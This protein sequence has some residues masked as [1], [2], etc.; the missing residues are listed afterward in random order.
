MKEMLESYLASPDFEAGVVASTKAS[1]GGS[2]YSVELHP[3]GSWSNLWDNQIG[4]LYVSDGAILSLP[5]LNCDAYQEC[6]VDGGMSEEEFLLAGFCNEQSEIA[7]AVREQF[8]AR[9]LS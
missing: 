4:N 1:W 6:V 5:S 3:D 2:G 8:A 7:D 9:S